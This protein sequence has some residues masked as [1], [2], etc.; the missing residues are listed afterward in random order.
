MSVRSQQTT[1]I[2]IPR[3]TQ[4]VAVKAIDGPIDFVFVLVPSFS[5]IA[6]VTAIEVLRV[7]NQL[8]GRGLYTMIEPQ[9]VGL[10]MTAY[11]M[12]RTNRHEY[13]WFEGLARFVDKEISVTEFHRLSGEIDFLLKV[14]LR[15]MDD[16]QAFYKRMTQQISFMDVSTSFAFEAVK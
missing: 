11:V 12:L 13:E 8:S 7:A 2:R 1:P 9:S 3:G 4:H 15:D 6:L 14:L 16:Y 10:T 5:M